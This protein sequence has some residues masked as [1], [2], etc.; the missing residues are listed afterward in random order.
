MQR[1][2]WLKAFMLQLWHMFSIQST[3][4]AS[5]HRLS[6]VKE[7]VFESAQQLSKLIRRTQ[8]TNVN[9]CIRMI[10][11]VWVFRWKRRLT[12]RWSSPTMRAVAA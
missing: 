4:F 5:I 7:L 6:L 8:Y 9:G 11:V 10:F 3:F 2:R 1:L 12:V